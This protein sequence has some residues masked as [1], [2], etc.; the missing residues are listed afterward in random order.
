MWKPLPRP[1]YLDAKTAKAGLISFHSE[2]A[3]FLR[4]TLREQMEFE[5]EAHA[6]GDPETPAEWFE[7]L[8]TLKWEDGSLKAVWRDR[9]AFHESA[10]EF[11][12]NG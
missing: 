7:M 12:I 2:H 6:P 5:L 4:N 10:L 8:K 3:E 11:L 1:A 9:L